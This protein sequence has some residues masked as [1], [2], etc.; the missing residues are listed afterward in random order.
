[1]RKLKMHLHLS[2][3]GYASDA[4]GGFFWIAYSDEL[5]TRAEALT[6]R[7][8]TVVFGPKTYKGMQGYWPTVL[9][10]ADATPGE[11]RHAEW[12]ARSTKVVVST[13]LPEAEADWDKSVLLRDADGLAELKRQPG[14]DLLSFGCP[15]LVSSC[16]RAGLV[17]ELHIFLNP[18]ILAGSNSPFT[19]LTHTAMALKEAVPLAGGVVALCYTPKPA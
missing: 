16:L 13:S 7:T 10:N 8:D 9:G 2:L 5:A 1:M 15:G 18:T 6:A 12:L 14:G 3:D 17:D 19:G 4:G 11:K